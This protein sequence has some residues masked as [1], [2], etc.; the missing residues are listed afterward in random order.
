MPSVR[1]PTRADGA[2]GLLNESIT[3]CT[4][5]FKQTCVHGWGQ[6]MHEMPPSCGNYV[7]QHV[8]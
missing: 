7:G 5:S 2:A 6:K 8:D 1:P 3:Y 4:P